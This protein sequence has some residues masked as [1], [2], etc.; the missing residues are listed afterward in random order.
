M[1]F[2][3]EDLCRQV[4]SSALTSG[5]ALLFGGRQAGK[6]TM[7]VRILEQR[8]RELSEFNGTGQAIVPV[9]LNLMRLPYDARPAVFF[10]FAA[11]EILAACSRVLPGLKRQKRLPAPS[12]LDSF[13]RFVLGLLSSLPQVDLR[14]LL[15]VDE[16][17]RILGERFPS[18]F[19]DNLF[20]LLYGNSPT[21]AV[22][23]IV[24]AGAQELYRF[25]EDGT[26]PLGSRAAKHFVTSLGD[27]SVLA[28]LKAFDEHR[29]DAAV[30]A[31]QVYA[32][33]GGH[34]GLTSY[35][36][37]ILAVKAPEPLDVQSACAHLLR[38]RSELFQIWLY[39]FSPEARLAQSLLLSGRTL[40]IGETARALERS[41]MAPFRADRA[42]EELVFTGIARRE[43]DRL[44][45]TNMLFAEVAGRYVVETSG[46]ETEQS[47]WNLIEQVEVALRG[48]VRERFEKKWGTLSDN[49]IEQALGARTWS[50]TMERLNRGKAPY[51]Y[52]N[53]TDRR[54][55]LEYA[56]ISQLA[57]LM[58]WR[59]AWNLFRDLFRDKR[60][61]EDIVSEIVVV[62]NE[63]A[64]FRQVPTREL[65][66]CRLR[67]E[68][69]LSI[70]ARASSSAG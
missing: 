52:T 58:V 66:R 22:C 44:L 68:D 63:K 12:T 27:D 2:G 64:H 40:S 60:E 70:L 3:R 29:S 37:R 35:L 1:C 49:K 46:S 21:N 32:H 14:L 6:T 18:G 4:A 48:L 50:M 36:A 30:I 25:A 42:W 51:R 19:R 9:Y 8:R 57:T 41:G 47:V 54:D 31:E 62:R 24:F 11:A 10:Q 5:C 13:E 16:A 33:T 17:K 15:L 23:S 26:S 39:S 61:L 56:Y 28:I 20:A 38:E 7:L 43:S 55:V 59:E 67:C 53:G 34:A 65:D 45:L 69:L